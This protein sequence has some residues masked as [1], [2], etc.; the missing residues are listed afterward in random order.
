MQLKFRFD[1][2]RIALNIMED[3]LLIFLKISRVK[4]LLG[5]VYY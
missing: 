5:I 2:S 4:T 3:W 1:H